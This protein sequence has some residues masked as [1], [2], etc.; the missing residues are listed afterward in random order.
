MGK[1]RR[2]VR[3]DGTGHRTD[4]TPFVLRLPHRFNAD[5]FPIARYHRGQP[6][7]HLNKEYQT[8]EQTLE[9]TEE[10]SKKR[11]T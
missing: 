1:F 8:E 3:D 11:A 4:K 5:I 7:N 6:L 10:R 2:F 9:Q